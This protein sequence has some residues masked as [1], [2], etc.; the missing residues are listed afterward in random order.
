MNAKHPNKLGQS[1]SRFFQEYLPAQRGMSLHTVHT[2]RDAIVLFLR[3][4]ASQ[5]GKRIEDLDLYIFTYE[6]ISQFLAFLE[7][8]RNNSISTRN[9]RLAALHTLARFLASEEPEH[10]ADWQR[11]LALPFKRGA[12]QAPIDYFESPEIEA[13][14]NQIDRSGKLGRRDFALFSLMFNTGARVQEVLDLRFCDVRT[15]TPCQVR[16]RG[17]GGK[18]RLCP[19]WTHTASLLRELQGASSPVEDSGTVIFKNRNGGK[20]TRFGV[21]YLLRKYVTAAGASL[22]S[23][24]NKHLHPHSLRHSTAIALL[25]SGVDFASVSQWLGHASLNTTMNYARM[26]LDLKRQTLSQVY[27][28]VLPV[29]SV[30]HVSSPEVNLIGWL[31]RL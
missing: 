18:I 3:F 30:G 11:I 15:E 10:L 26:D 2:Y 27:P 29:P 12:R 7:Q 23:L 24:G 5:C 14:L 17:K 21:R 22:E 25:K 28:D 31:K 4:A 16:F 1:L 6:L 13:F 9:S 20:L 8:E 19:I